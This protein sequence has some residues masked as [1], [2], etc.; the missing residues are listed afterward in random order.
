MALT[1]GNSSEEGADIVKEEIEKIINEVA[2]MM[3]G[4]NTFVQP[5]F[6]FCD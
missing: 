3:R 4:T 2:I 6:S 1:I 5:E